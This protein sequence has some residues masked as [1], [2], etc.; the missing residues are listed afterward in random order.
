MPLKTQ[1]Y[2]GVGRAL[3]GLHWFWCNGIG[4]CSELTQEPQGS[5]PFLYSDHRV[6]AELGQESQASF[7]VEAWNSVSLSRCSRGDGPLVELYLETAGFSG[8]CTG[9]SGPLR[10]ATSSTGLHSKEVSGHRVLI[11]S[12]PGNQGP[13]EC[14]TTHEATSRI[15]S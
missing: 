1:G 7:W 14:G 2:C 3:S 6:P 12:R 5:S 15:S 9:V 10:V 8:R 4:P 13:S 11:K